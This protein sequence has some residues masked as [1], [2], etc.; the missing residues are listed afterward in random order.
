M[1]KHVCFL[2]RLVC[3]LIALQNPPFAP[4]DKK[5]R[6]SFVDMFCYLSLRLIACVYITHAEGTSE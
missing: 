2:Q 5:A 3:T 6:F 1:F 4:A